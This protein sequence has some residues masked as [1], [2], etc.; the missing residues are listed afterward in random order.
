MELPT[1]PENSPEPQQRTPER[2]ASAGS[3]SLFLRLW[4]YG[5]PTT[6]PSGL[7]L[8][9]EAEISGLIQEIIRDG[10][11][12]IASRQPELWSANFEDAWHALSTAKILQQRFLT[13]H[14]ETEP[15]QVVPSILI[16]PT[17]GDKRTGPDGAL[18]EDMLAN[19]TSAQIL[20]AESIY[21]LMKGAP[22]LR[23]NPKPVRKAG[24]TFGPEGIYEMLWTDESTYGHLRQAGRAGLKSLGRYH[25]QEELGHGAMGAVYKAHDELIGRT[26]ALKTIAIDRNAPDRDEL[27]ERL[28]QEAKAAGG[29]DH[30]NIITIY[31]VGQ[32]DDTV[33]LSMQHVK[34][35]TLASLL[36]DVGV[37]SLA[38]FLSW[39]DQICAA[40]GFAHASGV[41]HRDLKPANLMV[42]DEGVIKVLDFGIAKLENT[43][44][45]QTGLVVGTPSYMAPEQLAGKKVDQRADIFS[46]GSVFYEFVTR[47]RPFHGDVT[48]IMYKIVHEDPVAPSLINP[49]VPGG[50]DAVIRKA[51]AKE[52][53][54][55]F[56]TCEEMRAAFAEQAA[57]MN[58][59]PAAVGPAAVKAK[60]QQ[61]PALPSFLL[62]EPPPKRRSVWPI[63]FMLLFIGTGAWAFYVHTTT[64]SY[65]AFI[66]TLTGGARQLP[67]TLRDLKPAPSAGQD[68]ATSAEQSNQSGTK[69]DADS[70]A[71]APGAPAGTPNPASG[72]VPQAAPDDS[73]EAT[74]SSTGSSDGQPSSPADGAGA[75]VTTSQAPA[76]T[77]A[78]KS[79]TVPSA[80]V[81]GGASNE[82]ADN[83]EKSPFSPAGK[84]GQVNS[85]LA[86]QTPKKS[87]Q[88]APTVDGFTRKNI[89][90]L[91]RVADIAARRGDYRLAS[92][93][94]NLILKLDHSNARA[95]I[96]LRLI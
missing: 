47:E 9:Q 4:S 46:L 57:R 48:T 54:E 68:Q 23:F 18:P 74:P 11:G 95:R 36:A 59:R 55:R 60:P 43:S 96:G 6:P 28:K 92:Y 13:F 58:V 89:P 75:P 5:A 62:T 93:D 42:T 53:K 20:I 61:E 63:V 22:G 16:Y 10:N 7:I 52:P 26:V 27:I 77:T 72:T 65:P 8:G 94:Y 41:I 69:N 35:V 80:A 15:Q 45:T 31:D 84:D 39:A 91:L 82:A 66:N 88:T 19:V 25:I 64:G 76:Q 67:Q 1:P 21:E 50:I 14:R 24:E 40:V 73:G 2:E 3:V 12:S 17:D 51:L 90:E 30:P 29:L 33:Y 38:T 79:G 34:G 86:M 37:P 85:T 78:P 87:R 56:Q 49:A 81:S 83:V 44:L 71:N 32:E 70:S